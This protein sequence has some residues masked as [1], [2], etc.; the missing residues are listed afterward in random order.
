VWCQVVD[1]KGVGQ[2]LPAVDRVVV[3]KEGRIHAQGTLAEVQV[4]F[5]SSLLLSSLG[6][7]DTKIYEP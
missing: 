7:I 1:I 3:I 4:F 2:V 6:L 5:L